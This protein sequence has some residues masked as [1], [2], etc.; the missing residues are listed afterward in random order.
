[1]DEDGGAAAVEFGPQ[2]FEV[3]VAE[4]AAVGVGHQD[5]AVGTQGVQRVRGLGQGGVHVGQ[6][7]AGEVAEAA[8]VVPDDIGAVLVDRAGE[9]A[10]LC[11]AAQV[12]AGGGDRQ[13]AGGD[14][15]L[16]HHREGSW[17]GSRRGWP[18]RRSEAVR[19]EGLGPE[20]R[21]DVLVDVDTGGKVM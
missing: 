12:D 16:V 10:R 11:V 17:S 15:L 20:G 7:N 4:V 1:M 21:D 13:Y 9:V 5:D 8:G 2:G 18:S 6:R 3:G 14:A 19:G